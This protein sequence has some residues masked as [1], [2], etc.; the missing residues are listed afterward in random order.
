MI[1]FSDPRWLWGLLVLPL[2]LLFEWRAMRRTERE[3]VESP[4]CERD[5]SCSL[6][7]AASR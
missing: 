6:H 3:I 2:A 5:Q 7:C 1:V 4:S